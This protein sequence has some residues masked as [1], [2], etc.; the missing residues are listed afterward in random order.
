M[1]LDLILSGGTVVDGSGNRDPFR[2]DVGVLGDHIQDVGNLSDAQ[3]GRTIDARGK[4]VAP[5]FIDVHLF[6]SIRVQQMGNDMIRGHHIA[7]I[8]VNIHQVDRV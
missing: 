6:I 5:G 7:Q 8:D 2:A 4:I 3:S 1:N